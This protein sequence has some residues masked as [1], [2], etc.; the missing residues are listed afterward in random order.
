MVEFLNMILLAVV[1]GLTEFLP[2]SSSGHLVLFQ[3][4]LGTREGDVFFDIILHVGTLGS[5]LVVYRR[6]VRRLLAFDREARRYQMSLAAG[7]LPAV[8]VGLLFRSQIEDLF[9]SPLFAAGGLVFTAGILFSTRFAAAD[10]PLADPW[11]PRAPSVGRAFFIGF[12]QV[13]AI[14]PGI[15]RSGTTIA[16]ALWAGLPRAEAARF[17]F[18]LSIPAVGGALALQLMDGNSNGMAE[19]VRLVL[20]G[21]VAFGVGLAAI[22]WTA[23]AVVQAHFWKFSIYCLL[24]GVA[25]L[26][27]LSG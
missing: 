16:A 6:E 20:A 21:L 12:A 17:S 10:H 23:L 4:F 5:I 19:W 14:L 9:H 22:R 15:S 8:V 24:L 25:V 1:Q 7:T 18:L 11:E 2:V 3:T 13:F 26:V 27:I